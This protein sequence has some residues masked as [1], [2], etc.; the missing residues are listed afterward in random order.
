MCVWVYYVIHQNVCT[1]CLIDALITFCYCLLTSALLM[2]TLFWFLQAK[3]NG[4]QSCVIIIRVMR[5]LCQRIPAFALLNNW[6]LELL[7]E[8]AVSSSQQPLGPGEAFRRGPGICDPC[9]KDTVD[10]LTEVSMQEKE[11]LTAS[12]QHA[13]RL[14]AFRQLHK[15]LGIDPLP[16]GPK[17]R[18][19]RGGRSFKR[20]R[21][22]SGQ[23]EGAKKEK[24]EGEGEVVA[25]AMEVTSAS[26]TEVKTDA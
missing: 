3:A 5:D 18:R 1:V 2:L 24:K 11:E 20:R 19:N 16:A 26:G 6:A 10:A 12:A 25:E 14:T 22:D 9:E 4:L 17:F 8:K 15:V 13:L 21:E 23:E 7:V